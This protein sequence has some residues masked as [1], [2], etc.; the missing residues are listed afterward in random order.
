MYIYRPH[1]GSLSDSMM[2]VKEFDT[3]DDLLD[4]V[5]SD[6]SFLPVDKQAFSREDIVFSED[7]GPDDR[8]GWADTRYVCVK[9]FYDEVYDHPQCVGYVATNYINKKREGH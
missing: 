1:R 2:V 7:L 9:R 6:C 8:I 4:Y 3:L 5:V